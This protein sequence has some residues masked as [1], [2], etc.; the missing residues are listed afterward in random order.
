MAL[1]R[2]CHLRV[3]LHLLFGKSRRRSVHADVE[4]RFR[5]IA[6]M[7]DID[8]M[9]PARTSI[10]GFR[11]VLLLG[12]VRDP[13]RSCQRSKYEKVVHARRSVAPRMPLFEVPSGDH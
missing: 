12:F 3:V 5:H 13:S 1:L 10:R 2:C 7:T 9:V 6:A 4:E 8:E 11:Q